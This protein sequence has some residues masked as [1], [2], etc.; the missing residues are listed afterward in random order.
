MKNSKTKQ[1]RS[2]PAQPPKLIK[3]TLGDLVIS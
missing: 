1:G 3:L 2:N